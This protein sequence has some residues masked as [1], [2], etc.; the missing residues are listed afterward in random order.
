[1]P[2]V[3]IP[4]ALSYPFSN[5]GFGNSGDCPP[6]TKARSAPFYL[7]WAA[8]SLQ[9]PTIAIDFSNRSDMPD[10]ITSVY[11]DNGRCH[12]GVFLLFPDTS[13]RLLIPAFHRGFFP[14]I[15]NTRRFIAGVFRPDLGV[16]DH[17][18]VH[19]LNWS[20]SPIEGDALCQNITNITGFDPANA[21]TA[22]PLFASTTWSRMRE[23]VVQLS[24]LVAGAGGF[25]AVLTIEA[26]TV[27]VASVGL[28][29][30]AAEVVDANVLLHLNNPDV[31]ALAWT[32]TWTVVAG[33]ATT[34]G[35]DSGSI[36][37][38]LDGAEP[39]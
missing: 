6:S 7:D 18:I 34:D 17:T 23:L 4:P 35:T 8:V 1:M 27:I 31:A 28:H 19:A 14:V 29:L 21:A 13:F 24:G 2:N 25:Q 36:N 26:D 5:V 37:L 22:Q 9:V 30:A 16:D 38:Y 33:A 20:P 12:Q 11:V 32:Y 3:N 39:S 10:Q 15:T